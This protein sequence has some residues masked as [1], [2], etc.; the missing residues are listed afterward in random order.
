MLRNAISW[1]VIGRGP[2][3]IWGRFFTMPTRPYL[4]AMLMQQ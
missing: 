1:G 2:A 4:Q 3:L